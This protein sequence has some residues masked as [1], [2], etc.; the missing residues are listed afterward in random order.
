MTILWLRNMHL[1]I[2][3]IICLMIFS[4]ISIFGVII[5]NNHLIELPEL[6]FGH[7]SMF[8]YITPIYIFMIIPLMEVFEQ[9]YVI[10]RYKDIS[11]LSVTLHIQIIL[12]SLTYTILVSLWTVI[13]TN[14]FLYLSLVPAT[15]SINVFQ[16]LY[17]ILRFIF[18]SELALLLKKLLKKNVFVYAALY[19]IIVIEYTLFIFGI[20]SYI[21]ITPEVS[22]SVTTYGYQYLLIEG[23][24]YVLCTIVLAILNTIYTIKSDIGI[25]V[26]DV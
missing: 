13:V 18:F 5:P 21:Y 9:S 2:K 15:L 4:A 3:W 17:I 8:L 20:I 26:P 6:A 19:S 23:V 10:V 14:I 11:T 22:L 16:M 7:N 25:G 24:N 12:F 1:S